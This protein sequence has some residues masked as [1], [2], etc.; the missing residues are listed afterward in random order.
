MKLL[1]V[2]ICLILFHLSSVRAPKKEGEKETNLASTTGSSDLDEDTVKLLLE[3]AVQVPRHDKKLHLSASDEDRRDQLPHLHQARRLIRKKSNENS[4]SPRKGIKKNYWPDEFPH[5][6]SQT[7]YRFLLENLPLDLE[8]FQQPETEATSETPKSPQQTEN[9]AEEL[10]SSKNVEQEEELMKDTESPKKPETQAGNIEEE[11]KPSKNVEQK[12]ELIEDTESPKKPEEEGET[13]SILGTTESF[14]RREEKSLYEGCVPMRT[15]NLFRHDIR[16]PS[17]ETTHGMRT[18][19]RNVKESVLL[20]LY[21]NKDLYDTDPIKI[22]EFL[23]LLDTWDVVEKLSK[24]VA[25]VS[26]KTLNQRKSKKEKQKELENLTLEEKSARLKKRK[27]GDEKIDEAKDLTPEGVENVKEIAGRYQKRLKTLFDSATPKSRLFKFTDCQRTRASATEFYS[28]IYGK[29]KEKDEWHAPVETGDEGKDPLLKYDALC[30]H[31]KKNYKKSTLNA[32]QLVTFETGNEIK[33]AL[34]GIRDILLFPE[35]SITFSDG[36]LLYESCAFEMAWGKPSPWCILMGEMYLK[37]FEYLE[38]Y[39]Y[40]KNDGPDNDMNKKVGCFLFKDMIERLIGDVHEDEDGK[41]IWDLREGEE[42]EEEDENT[43]KEKH[44]ETEPTKENADKSDDADPTKGKTA[45]TGTGEG[46]GNI[47]AKEK[48]LET[49]PTKETK[50]KSGDP[51]PTK[52]E[53]AETDS[54]KKKASKSKKKSPKKVTFY[55]TH[56]TAILKFITH[57]RFLDIDDDEKEHLTVDNYNEMDNRKWRTARIGAF[58]TNISIN[59]MK[60]NKSYSILVMHQE[61]PVKLPGCKFELCLLDDFLKEYRDSIFNCN[62]KEMCKKYKS[63]MFSSGL[64]PFR[65]T[66]KPREFDN[67]EHPLRT[68]SFQHKE[69]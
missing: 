22:D 32:H 27:G 59:L 42:E 52:G 2:A 28:V 36:K 16:Y 50:E 67:Y 3:R 11:L 34:K 60:C 53:A 9:V 35:K 69:V 41:I 44:P 61:R 57:L 14:R 49:D 24:D 29:P 18:R 39:E 45:D 66:I 33:N 62:Y 20:K 31:W 51:D 7:P 1:H 30:G 47:A 68:L 48:Q 46:D 37:V 12:E 8:Y 26:N 40:F 21:E 19:L 10:K 43:A 55:F 4:R 25:Y 15:W 6:G 23:N 5:I 38:D 64:L 63:G 56:L 65:G 54:V 17:K 58:G 13:G